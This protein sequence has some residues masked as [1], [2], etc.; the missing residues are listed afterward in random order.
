[1]G[2]G[3]QARHRP[4]EPQAASDEPLGGLG[5]REHC[6]VSEVHQ[7]AGCVPAQGSG[8]LAWRPAWEEHS[9]YVAIVNTSACSASLR[10]I[11]GLAKVG[12]NRLGW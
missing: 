7:A 10:M 9:T 2:D 11:A 12:I 1:M 5:L 4:D 6:R 3:R 8:H